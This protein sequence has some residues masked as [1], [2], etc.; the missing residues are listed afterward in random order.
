MLR[1]L[2]LLGLSIEQ[3]KYVLSDGIISPYLYD[4]LDKLVD[5]HKQ[6]TP[7]QIQGI[8]AWP[9]TYVIDWTRVVR[10]IDK[11]KSKG[12]LTA[13]SICITKHNSAEVGKRFCTVDGLSNINLNGIDV[14][15][16][17]VHSSSFMGPINEHLIYNHLKNYPKI[18]VIYVTSINYIFNKSQD[19]QI[20]LPCS[21]AG[22]WSD[23]KFVV[24]GTNIDKVQLSRYVDEVNNE[25]YTNN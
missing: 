12:N 1:D 23:S 25:Q 4:N 3:M 11:I 6:Y 9:F 17:N 15:L 13:A 7:D 14:L 18:I 8:F 5:R 24:N 19:I 20:T 16:L 10:L 2:I 21:T 22:I